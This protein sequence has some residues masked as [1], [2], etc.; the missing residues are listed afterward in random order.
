MIEF[1]EAVLT[2][3][4]NLLRTSLENSL[5][6][7]VKISRDKM[8]LE[9]DVARSS[10]DDTRL[11]NLKMSSLSPKFIGKEEVKYIFVSKFICLFKVRLMEI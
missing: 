11:P 3:L 4:L 5:R 7:D 2:S 9:S 10:I 1:R 6:G 8:M